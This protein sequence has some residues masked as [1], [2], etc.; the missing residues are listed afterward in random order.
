MSNKKS[1]F[2]SKLPGLISEKR[3]Q[4]S[5]RAASRGFPKHLER[6]DEL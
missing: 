2:Q 6:R 3:K 4:Y 5:R 1:Y